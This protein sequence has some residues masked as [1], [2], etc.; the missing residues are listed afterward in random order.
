MQIPAGKVNNI[1][2]TSE[3]AYQHHNAGK[4]QKTFSISARFLPLTIITYCLRLKL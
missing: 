2:P 1:E 4:V 3:F